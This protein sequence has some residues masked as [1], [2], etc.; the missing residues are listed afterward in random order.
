MGWTG[1]QSL[2]RDLHLPTAGLDF[3]PWKSVRRESFGF[4]SP[5]LSTVATAAGRANT[6]T[7]LSGLLLQFPMSSWP[8]LC[9]GLP[10]AW[11]W[12]PQ[13]SKWLTWAPPLTL[14]SNI[15]LSMRPILTL[16]INKSQ[17]SPPFPSELCFFH[18]LTHSNIL[19]NVLIYHFS[20]D[21]PVEYVS[22]GRGLPVRGGG[23]AGARGA[24][25]F[26]FVHWCLPKHL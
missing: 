26:F 21:A 12:N 4:Q 23:R 24:A 2:Q 8:H 15:S 11:N 6:G 17:Q 20:K 5:S 7:F 9:A 22:Q 13:N 19:H 18:N 10:S 1:P 25:E 3:Q 16:F 14:Y